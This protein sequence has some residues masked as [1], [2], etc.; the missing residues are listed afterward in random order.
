MSALLVAENEHTQMV[1]QGKTP[2]NMTALKH[3]Q[4]PN[5]A[6]YVRTNSNPGGGH[7]GTRPDIQRRYSSEGIYT[8]RQTISNSNDSN[9]SMVVKHQEQDH[10]KLPAIRNENMI[11][12]KNSLSNRASY[13]N[14]QTVV[15]N[16]NIPPSALAKDKQVSLL[17]SF[18]REFDVLFSYPC[19]IFQICL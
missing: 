5:A 13:R 17:Y 10:K 1:H 4:G 14:H 6:M 12:G 18:E 15:H 7:E 9:I 19:Y 11:S 8:T 3:N 16:N 2:A